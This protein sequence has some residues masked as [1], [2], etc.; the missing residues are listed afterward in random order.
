[1]GIIVES[2]LNGT[3]QQYKPAFEKV[4]VGVGMGI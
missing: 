1:M 3:W 2:W 4:L